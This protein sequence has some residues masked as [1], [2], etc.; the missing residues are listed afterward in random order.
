MKQLLN[1][2]C[3]I[4][5]SLLLGIGIW[6]FWSVGYPFALSYHEQNQLFL[7]TWDYFFERLSVA[8]G[9]AD[10]LGEFIVQFFYI[11][12]LGAMLIALLM[13]IG[14]FLVAQFT[15][16]K[17][18]CRSASMSFVKIVAVILSLLFAAALTWLMGDVNVMWVFPVAIVLALSLA[19]ISLPRRLWWT[20]IFIIPIAYWLIGPAVWIYILLRAIEWGWHRLWSAVWLMVVMMVSYFWLLPQWP[21]QQVLSGI[22]YYRIP[23]QYPQLNGFDSETYELIHMDYLVRNER[24]DDILKRASESE[25]RTAFWSN[26]V[27]LALSQKRQLAER[28]FEFYQSGDDAIIMPRM[29]DQTSNLPSAEAFFRLGMI[30]SAQ[31]YMFDIQES[32]LNGRMSGRCTKR[33][34]ECMLING[35]YQTAAKYIALLKKS[36]FYRSW[37]EEAEQYLGNESKID[38]HPVWGRL[39]RFRF[40]TDFLYSHP[41]KYKILGLLFM[42][43]HDNKMALDYFLAELLLRGDVPGFAQYLPLAEQYGGYSKMPAGYEDAIRTIQSHGNA[44]GTK[45]GPYVQRMLMQKGGSE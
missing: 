25:V 5:F 19:S 37:A 27:N 1:R 22:S 40:K 4:G 42:E 2:Y 20:D 44:S 29:R 10:W 24:W 11:P 41:E 3:Y 23:L 39:R 18:S 43:N 16:K 8:G 13:T 30:N 21:L 28:Q 31:R 45:Y 17:L 12:W 26:C 14:I 15:T 34:V 9:L 36:L 6:V 38:H 35:H 32:I 33:I 7:F